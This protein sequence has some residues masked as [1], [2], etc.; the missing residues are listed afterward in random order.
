MP[1]QNKYNGCLILVGLGFR[2][3]GLERERERLGGGVLWS[4]PK[5]QE[6]KIKRATTDMQCM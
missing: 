1:K 5:E 3:Q 2:A 6:A 4:N